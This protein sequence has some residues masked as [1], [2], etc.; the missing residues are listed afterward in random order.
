VSTFLGD[1]VTSGYR[2]AQL[3][4][5]IAKC[6]APFQSLISVEKIIVTKGIIPELTNIQD[7][8]KRLAEMTHAIEINASAEYTK[9]SIPHQ[10]TSEVDSL[11]PVL[12]G[13]GAADLASL[14][15]LQRSITADLSA[16]S[17]QIKAANEYVT[18][19]DNIAKAHTILYNNREKILTKDGAKSALTQL[20][21][22]VKDAY[23]ALEAL[24]NI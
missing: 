24:K 8:T 11:N 9:A 19:L 7:R 22:L 18:A 1:L 10:P 16:L 2:Q 5:T 17:L 14:L 13:S 15:L 23:T 3:K 4:N 21:P 20:T 12:Q 6:E